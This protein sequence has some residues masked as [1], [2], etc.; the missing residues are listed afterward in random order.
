MSKK[1]KELPT[2]EQI[3]KKNKTKAKVFG[4]LTPVV[5]CLFLSLSLIFFWLSIKNSVGNVIE[6]L[7][8]LDKEKYS[9]TEI[10]ENYR[11]LVNKWGE[12][13]LIG[14]GSAGL[15]VRYVD[16]G[17]AMFSDMMMLYATL[18][19]A[20]LCIGIILGKIVFPL[21]VKH[22]KNSND[23]M[24]DIATLKSAS[25]IAQISKKEWF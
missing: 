4:V 19:V 1:V 17:N 18:S 12:W 8:L 5:W 25:Q 13:E 14:A 16:I 21:L 10:L 9:G 23:E 11:F 20:T 15:V 24:V 22:F 6:I 3:Y 7:D 2:S